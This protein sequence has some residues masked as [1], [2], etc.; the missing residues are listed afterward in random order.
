MQNY[1]H[2]QALLLR[3]FKHHG[4]CSIEQIRTASTNLLKSFELNAN[5]PL[6]KVFFPLVRKGFVDFKGDGKYQITSP[7]IIFYLKE[8]ISVGINLLDEQ[9]EIITNQF[10]I[11]NIDEFDVICFES[12]RESI[13]TF[14]ENNKCEYSEPNISEL[15]LNFPKISR[16]VEQFERISI[17]SSGEYYDINEHRWK[18]NKN[19]IVGVFRL[20]EDSQKFYL[21]T[22]K[23]D[24]Q[25][26]DFSINPEGRL[27]AESYQAMAENIS[28]LHYNVETNTL[29]IKGINI[30]ILIDRILRMASFP[31]KKGVIEKPGVTIYK[32]I[33]NSAVKQLNRIFGIKTIIEV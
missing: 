22:E 18:K 7:T 25:I 2:L 1:T 10:K 29:T 24:L 4:V 20:S 16:V 31:L 11:I 32:N 17:I 15:L 3:W 30:P 27:L 6:F 21:R 8:Q 26:P 13:R 28:F 5:H 33:T 23:E 9:K 12:K 19:Q 14:C